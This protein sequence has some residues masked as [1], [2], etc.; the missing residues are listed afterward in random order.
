MYDTYLLTYVNLSL[1][2]AFMSVAHD[3]TF[4]V[5]CA[6]RRDH[7]AATLYVLQPSVIILVILIIIMCNKNKM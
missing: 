5:I 3:V 4:I 1:I 2:I 6:F 7:N